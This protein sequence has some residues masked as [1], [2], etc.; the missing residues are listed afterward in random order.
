MQLLHVAKYIAQA[1]NVYYVT[2]DRQGVHS[3]CSTK[4]C[5]VYVAPWEFAFLA[6]TLKVQRGV[7]RSAH[8]RGQGHCVC[9]TRNVFFICVCITPVGDNT[10]FVSGQAQWCIQ[11]PIVVHHCINYA[12]R[13]L[14]DQ[15]PFHRYAGEGVENSVAQPPWRQCMY[16]TGGCDPQLFFSWSTCP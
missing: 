11:S 5:P 13:T 14:C 8:L 6:E 9:S 3:R 16:I 7:V 12:V 2:V 10:G 1:G 4:L 15:A